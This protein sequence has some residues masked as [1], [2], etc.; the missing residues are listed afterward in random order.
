MLTLISLSSARRFS[1]ILF[2]ILW[3]GFAPAFALPTPAPTMVES[4]QLLLFGAEQSVSG[5]SFDD[6]SPCDRSR[7]PTWVPSPSWQPKAVLDFQDV[8]RKA[9]ADGR[10]A[11]LIVYAEGCPGWTRTVAPLLESKEVL[12]ITRAEFHTYIV[13][14]DDDE[15]VFLI[16]G[17]EFSA[18]QLADMLEIEQFPTFVLFEGNG[19]LIQLLEYPVS[20]RELRAS[21]EH[22]VE[23]ESSSA[24]IE[25]TRTYDAPDADV[26]TTLKEDFPILPQQVLHLKDK[27]DQRPLAVFFEKPVCDECDHF[28][29]HILSDPKTRSLLSRFRIARFGLSYSAV[30]IGTPERRLTVAEWRRE[31]GVSRMPTV[32]IFDSSARRIRYTGD[33]TDLF[34]FQSLLEYVISGAYESEPSFP[35]FLWHRA[36]HLRSHGNDVDSHVYR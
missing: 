36:R 1:G 6:V 14:A 16:E 25:R 27:F 24:P 8:F 13:N 9:T 34:R 18:P 10:L 17:R 20:P 2:L 29:K 12:A 21:L 3:H 4:S 35:H 15:Q 26:H 28:W 7:D 23:S 31:L 30:H 33:D 19:R 22:A 11:M 32:V 5:F